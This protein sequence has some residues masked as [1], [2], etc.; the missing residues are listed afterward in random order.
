MINLS[1]IQKIIAIILGILTIG[2]AVFGIDRYVAK[3]KDMVVV[4]TTL[5]EADEKYATIQD[6]A[7]LDKRINLN[8]LYDQ[9][10]KL[11]Q[12]IWQL[13]DRFKDTLNETIKRMLDESKA[14]LELLK[15][16]IKKEQSI[17]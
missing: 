11:Q 13:E 10:Y 12:R 3:Q 1:N 14:D 2:G 7:S 9:L 4:Q 6:V 15:E 16:R 5:G 17:R 8:S